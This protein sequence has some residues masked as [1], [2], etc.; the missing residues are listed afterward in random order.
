MGPRPTWGASHRLAAG[1][2][3]NRAGALLVC[4]S[5]AVLTCAL[6]PPQHPRTCCRA[7]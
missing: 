4:V 7:C 1:E 2:R 3:G 6:I 5:E